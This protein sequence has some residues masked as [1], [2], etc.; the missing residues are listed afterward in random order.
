MKCVKHF[1]DHKWN[2]KKK[3]SF[4]GINLRDTQLPTIDLS[5]TLI[6]VSA[7][8]S[9][10]LPLQ[11]AIE[12]ENKAAHALMIKQHS[13]SS[14]INIVDDIISFKALHKIIPKEWFLQW[15]GRSRSTGEKGVGYLSFFIKQPPEFSLPDGIFVTCYDT[16]MNARECLGEWFSNKQW[17][18]PIETKL[19]NKV[20]HLG[21]K[22]SRLT[23]GQKTHLSVKYYTVT[24]LYQDHKNFI[25][26]YHGIKYNAFYLPEVLLE[27]TFSNGEWIKD[28]DTE[29]KEGNFRLKETLDSLTKKS[30]LLDT[31]EN[32]L[33]YRSEV[34]HF[35]I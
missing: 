30:G 34:R 12:L 19:I 29:W 7:D 32:H 1:I 33:L 11:K 3:I 8:F 13:Q 18:Q 21:N 25:R 5:D 15:I 17:T 4:S 31:S 22:S 26:G 6:I 14:Y 16:K 9:H 10:F 27:H 2:I 28:S 20:I 35:K 24:Y 23:G